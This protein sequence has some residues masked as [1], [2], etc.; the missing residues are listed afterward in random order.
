MLK[1]N[2]NKIIIERKIKEF[3]EEDC[4]FQDVS[5]KIIPETA[6]STAK[7]IV[8]SNGFV[9]GLEELKIL[10]SML[11]VY[12]NFLKKDGD[13]VKEED[14]IVELKGGIR[15]I[16]F[17][18]RT[19]LNLV[20]F[21]SSI[22]STVREY[23]KIIENSR[24]NIKIACTRKTHPG[25]RIF[26]KKATELGQGD[27][28]R[29]SLSDMVLLKDTHLRYYKGNV[30]KMLEDIKKQSSFSRKIEIELE[31][32]ND[33]IIATRNGA[34]II[35]LDNMS[36]KMVEEAINLLEKNNLRNNVIV[37][38]SGGITLENVRDYL[39]A[40]PDIISI[41]EITQFPSIKMDFSL[42]FD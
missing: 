42:R 34:D 10:Y 36:P 8:K 25:L 32:V 30:K 24:K 37:E 39:N 29:F 22:T 9:S 33:V 12:T 4:P 18:E 35:M 7:V 16:L 11:N 19:G 41:G 31:K 1:M 5:S 17:G 23:V 21:M 2:Y 40:E 3:L 20:T 6:Q 13:E 14:I 38:V 26:E 28:H 15:D 27:S